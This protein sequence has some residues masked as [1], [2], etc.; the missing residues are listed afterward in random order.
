MST[1]ISLGKAPESPEERA[2]LLAKKAH[3]EEHMAGLQ[4][5]QAQKRM[6]D[7]LISRKGYDDN[8]LEINQDFTF[9]L[10]GCSFVVRAD[11]IVRIE[12]KR[13]FT[14]KCV[15][16][17]MESWE[18]HSV[19]FGRVADVYQIPYAVITDSED[20]GMISTADGTLVAQG[21]DAI[22]SRQEAERMQGETKF[23]ACP[24]ERVEKEKRIL[25][26]FEAIKCTNTLINPEG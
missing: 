13:L 10:P 26:A 21:L 19:A 4:L 6:V 14:V 7:F 1:Y 23:K 24:S 9:E 8:D 15:M 5:T 2:L 3:M 18:R 22:P 11:I 17:S 16:S 12:G 20:A 25:Y